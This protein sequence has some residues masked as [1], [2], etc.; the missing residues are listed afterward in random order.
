MTDQDLLRRIAELADGWIMLAFPPDDTALE[1]IGTDEA[2]GLR[3]RAAIASAALLLRHSLGLERE[4]GAL[5]SAIEAAISAGA[6][7]APPPPSTPPGAW[8]RRRR[9]PPAGSGP[10]PPSPWPAFRPSWPS[11]MP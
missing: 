8:S 2:L 7:T 4:A 5:E 10:W 6:R 11:F 9:W 3:G 1:A